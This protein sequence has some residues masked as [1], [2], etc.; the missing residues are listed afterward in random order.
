MVE[1]RLVL[2]AAGIFLPAT[3]VNG[4]YKEGSFY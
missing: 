3:S 2:I 1:S 4:A